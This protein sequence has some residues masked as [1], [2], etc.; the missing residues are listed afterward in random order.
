MRLPLSMRRT[1]TMAPEVNDMRPSATTLRTVTAR[2]QFLQAG[3]ETDAY[4][5]FGLFLCALLRR[6]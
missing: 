6:Q 3:D 5:R 2:T 1:F 4:R